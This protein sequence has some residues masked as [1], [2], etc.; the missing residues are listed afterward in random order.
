M[1][2]I[3]IICNDKVISEHETSD[4]YYDAMMKECERQLNEGTLDSRVF[5]FN[6]KEQAKITK[7]IVNNL[8]YK[9]IDKK[10][11]ERVTK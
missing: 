11:P 3:I 8:I 2:K 9:L 7:Y 1:K 6:E 4:V 5:E 10:E